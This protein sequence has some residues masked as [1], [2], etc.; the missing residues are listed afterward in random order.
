MSLSWHLRGIVQ[1][2]EKSG[3]GVCPRRIFWGN[4][5]RECPGVISRGKRL[6]E[7]SEAFPGFGMGEFSGWGIYQGE[8]SDGEMS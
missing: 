1:S 5:F 2:G 6:A 8:T 3:W 7:F 4:V